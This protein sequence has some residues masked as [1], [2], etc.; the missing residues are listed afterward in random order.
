MDN[1]KTGAGS[2]GGRGDMLPG[3]VMSLWKRGEAR[4]HKRVW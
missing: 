4:C 1:P 2:G 3:M